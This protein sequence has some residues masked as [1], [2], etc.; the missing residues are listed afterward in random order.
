MSD[1]KEEASESKK[2][3]ATKVLMSQVKVGHTWMFSADDNNPF[4]V[5]KIMKVTT[6]GAR[7]QNYVPDPTK[8]KKNKYLRAPDT[9]DYHQSAVRYTPTNYNSRNIDNYNIVK[10]DE[11]FVIRVVL[12]QKGNTPYPTRKFNPRDDGS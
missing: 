9:L 10:W 8:N 5:S 2:S 4:W 12:G 6:E 3:K 11:G 1:E 7:V